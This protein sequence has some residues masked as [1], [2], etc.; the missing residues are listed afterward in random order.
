MAADIFDEAVVAPGDQ[1]IS[2]WKQGR[3]LPGAW[4]IHR[5]GRKPSIGPA[6]SWAHNANSDQ[7]HG[8]QQ[9][10]TMTHAAVVLSSTKR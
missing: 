3:S 5:R 7:E 1:D 10:P 4:L 2:T 6:H 8:H 9:D